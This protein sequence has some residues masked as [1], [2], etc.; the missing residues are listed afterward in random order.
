M[1]VKKNDTVEI[2]RGADRGKS[3]K[4]LVAYPKSGLVLVEG[5]NI[6]KRHMKPQKT[7]AKG[8][9]IDRAMPIRVDNVRLAGEKKGKKEKKTAKK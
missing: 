2:V 6:G 7:G 1:H 8:A 4:V 9:V 3:G 5:I